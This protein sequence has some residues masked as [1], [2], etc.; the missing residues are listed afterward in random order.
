MS[1]DIHDQISAF[2]DGELSDS[3]S[4]FL[5][6]RLNHDQEARRKVSH[7]SVIGAAI[8]GD[9]VTD[10]PDSLSRR[11]NAALD[12]QPVNASENPSES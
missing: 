11:V 5:V 6:R 1:K 8:R 4:E 3:E 9:L 7:Y 10:Q 12:G 2:I